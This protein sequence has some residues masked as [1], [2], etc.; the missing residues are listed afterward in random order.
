MY[1]AAFDA[2]NYF[3]IPGSPS[4]ACKLDNSMIVVEEN[5]RVNMNLGAHDFVI[6]ITGSQ[7]RY[8]GLWVEHALVLQALFPLLAE[9][10][11]V[12]SS[13]PRLRIIV[14]S[15]DL[16]GN[17]T[18]ALEVKFFFSNLYFII[19]IGNF[20]GHKCLFVKSLK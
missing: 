3:V 11:V 5:F 16:T 8:K 6:A 1:Y 10:S 12:D 19:K 15:Q 20:D 4:G 17:Y 13:S 9:F 18:A 2:G 7:F 14:L